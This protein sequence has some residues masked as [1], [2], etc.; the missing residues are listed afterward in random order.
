MRVLVTGG[1]GFIGS[2]LVYALVT[3][4]HEVGV[5][6][7][8]STG[9]AANLHPHAWF[10]TLDI[11]S[12]QLTAVVAEFAPDAVVHLA[13]QASV[14]VSIREPER[15]FAV[16]AEGTRAVARAAL[17]AGARRMVSAS[18]AAVYGEPDAALLPLPETAPK[19]PANPYGSSKL[20]A[21]GFLAEE[22]LGTS[23]DFASFRF[24][25]VYGPRQD[26][27]GEGGVV[28]LFCAAMHAEQP[29]VVFGTGEQTRDFIYVGDIVG[30]IIAALSSEEPLGTA[31]GDAA[32][33]NISTGF[34][35]SV[36]QLLMSLREASEYYGAAETRA[37]RAGDVDRSSL[38]PGKAARV[39]GWHAHQVL[40]NGL[41]MTW[42]W[43]AAGS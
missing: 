38:D 5:I 42:R 37:P 43:F 15:D 23:C 30:A 33:Y 3:G 2:N 8:L 19:A 26:A 4:G 35:T 9:K 27:A 16:N 6:D 41:A 12:P 29:P 17:A 21:E 32:A 1:A 20:A 10:R 14:S 13:A 34:E 40:D 25:N 31:A 11:V 24:A 28:A 7:D 22:L 36:N 18:S 39:F